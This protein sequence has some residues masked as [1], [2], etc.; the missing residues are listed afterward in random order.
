MHRFLILGGD[1]RQLYLARLLKQAGHELYLYY[2]NPSASL[3]EAMEGSHIIL[4]P[5]PFSKDSHAIHCV[6][7]LDDMA[8]S[9]FLDLLHEGH[10]LFGGS[11]P[12]S[13]TE[14]CKSHRI[15]C[16]DFMK[17]DEVACKNAVATAEGAVAEAISLSP[18][19]LRGSRCL[20]TGSGRCA[21]ALAQALSGMGARVAVS[22]RNREQLSKAFCHGYEAFPLDQMGFRIHE[23]GFLFNT[24]PA[25]VLDASLVA[26]MQP[27]AAVIDIASAPGGVDFEACS[28][29]GIRAK[30]C[31]GLPG[32]YS[33]MTSAVILYEAVMEHL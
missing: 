5:M 26:R 1:P 27:D 20:I 16:Y 8:I 13:V 12:P 22:G 21:E 2:D 33:P 31:P 19:N 11:I 15:P 29:L 25:M 32:R 28:R 14:Y 9:R 17:M 7:P 6:H 18:V 23:Y 3:E 4:C 10:I 30:L 24:I